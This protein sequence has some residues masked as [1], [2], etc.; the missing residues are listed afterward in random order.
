MKMFKKWRIS[1]SVKMRDSNSDDLRESE[2]WLIVRSFWWG[3]FLLVCVWVWVYMWKCVSVCESE[4]V[5]R[6]MMWD[7]VGVW[8]IE[9]SSPISWQIADVWSCI[10]MYH[11][12]QI[13]DVWSLIMHQDVKM[14]VRDVQEDA[15][16]L[17]R[18][19]EAMVQR[20]AI[21]RIDNLFLLW[22][23]FW[24]VK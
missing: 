17:C 3:V 24:P 23:F 6:S 4:V 16:L 5:L 14:V 1:F 22:L 9:I 12:W 7:V 15:H 13:A 10:K 8:H 2:L 19:N 20:V 11:G 21:F 18:S